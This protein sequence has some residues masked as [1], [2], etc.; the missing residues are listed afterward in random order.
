MNNASYVAGQIETADSD[1]KRESLIKDLYASL[2]GRYYDSNDA[3]AMLTIELEHGKPVA[4]VMRGASYE[5]FSEWIM[6]LEYKDGKLVYNDCERLWIT[7][8]ENEDLTE[9]TE[10]TNGSGYFSIGEWTL[11]WDGAEDEN[12]R[13]CVFEK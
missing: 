12:C 10:Y 4:K 7:A 9:E 8:D 6:T 2:E 1:A 3:H 13:D 11:Y 5:Q